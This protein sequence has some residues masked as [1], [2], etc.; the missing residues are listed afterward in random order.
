METL[1]RREGQV[2]LLRRFPLLSF[3]P[4]LALVWAVGRLTLASPAASLHPGLLAGAVAFDLTVTVTALFWLTAVRSGAAGPASLAIL[5][6]AGAS[7]AART[8]PADQRGWMV[9]VAA[10]GEAALLALVA[11]RGVHLHRAYRSASDGR[12]PE[13]ALFAAARQVLGPSRLTLA[14][15]TEAA[16]LWLAFASWRRAPHVPP[17]H[18][19]F[20]SHKTTGH[21]AVVVALLFASLAEVTGIHLLVARWSGAWAWGVS[22]L[23]GYG[24]LWLVADWRA[25]VLR[26]TLLGEETLQVRVG[27]RWSAR[28]PLGTLR[29][30]CPGPDARTHRGAFRASPLGPP[31]LYLHL[32]RPAEL[33]GLWGFQRQA[34][35]IGLRVDDAA[36]L[37]AALRRRLPQLG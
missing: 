4:L 33:H 9:A 12:S 30:V 35:V 14:L 8:L 20:S 28:I 5:F 15:A 13:D 34:E 11:W 17:K 27:L 21:G 32:T 25:V 10:L 1:R 31:T 36:A 3:A 37:T 23:A 29:R 16:M 26:P 18:T 19:A 24:V 6:A 2:T 7:L 22:A